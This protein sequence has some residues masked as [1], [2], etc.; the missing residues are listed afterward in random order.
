ML[1]LSALSFVSILA[2]V[3]ALSQ[4]SS[5]ENDVRAD[6]ISGVFAKEGLCKKVEAIEAGGP[7][8][9]DTVTETL[10]PD[11][12]RSWEGNCDFVTITEKE[13]G[14]SY[15]AKMQCIEG[16]EEWTETNTFDLDPSGSAITVWIEGEKH[17]YVKCGSGKGN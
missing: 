8:N 13:K 2:G 17:Q 12:F 14:R 9:I 6:F 4:P 10:T 15:E 7:K 5:A 16:P 3:L 1:R 11:G